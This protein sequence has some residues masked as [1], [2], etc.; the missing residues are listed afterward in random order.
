MT[1]LVSRI[2][3]RPVA[4][5]QRVA[6]DLG[7]TRRL[8]EAIPIVLAER[9][10][11]VGRQWRDIGCE[12]VQATAASDVSRHPRVRLTAECARYG[13]SFLLQSYAPQAQWLYEIH[14]T[15]GD[16]PMD[17]WSRSEIHQRKRRPA[18]LLKMSSRSMAL[19]TSILS[20]VKKSLSIKY[21]SSSTPCCLAIPCRKLTAPCLEREMRTRWL[22][23]SIALDILISEN[24]AATGDVRSADQGT[25]LSS[26]PERTMRF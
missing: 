17:S 24:S 3:W 25:A 20:S 19:A 16:G 9:P 26:S 1:V 10:L 2:L 22:Q 5:D 7:E 4:G 13:S 14:S 11:A 21:D 12:S 23:S 18:S 8:R 15:S 6:S